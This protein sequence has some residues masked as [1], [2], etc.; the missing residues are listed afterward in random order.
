VAAIC[1]EDWLSPTQAANRLG[2]SPQRVRQLVGEGKLAATITPLGRL[3]SAADVTALAAARAQS[4]DRPP[5][6]AA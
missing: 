3:I 2:L 1:S 5:D 4:A 6:N